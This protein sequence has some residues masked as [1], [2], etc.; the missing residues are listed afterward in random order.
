MNRQLLALLVVSALFNPGCKETT[1]EDQQAQRSAATTR[2]NADVIPEPGDQ[3]GTTT[4]VSSTK[5]G[6]VPGSTT[7]PATTTGTT[8]ALDKDP[9]DLQL[10]IPTGPIATVPPV[11]FE[12]KLRIMPLGASFTQGTGSKKAG[13]RGFLNK[14]L[15]AEKIDHLFVGS[16][17][18]QPGDLPLDQIQHEGHPGSVIEAGTSGRAGVVDNLSKWIGKGGASPQIIT[19]LVGSNDVDLNY[20][21]DQIEARYDK[22]LTMI[23]DAKTGL[24]PDAIV[25]ASSI[26]VIKDPVKE[27]RNK[28]YNKIIESLVAKH[29]A[30]GER[31]YFVD[32]HAVLTAGD[33]VDNLH[34]N[35]SGYEKV[36]KLFGAKI[37]EAVRIEN[38][39]VS[40]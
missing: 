22:L 37:K 9:N 6:S 10:P 16:N 2:N 29:K 7:A 17:K 8:S 33:M 31:I 11:R 40:K 23:L 25:I 13:Y 24:R 28:R 12:G 34:A 5:D 20:K 21:F 18:D 27:E 15:V 35:D 14:L 26:A 4:P 19:I 39:K 1:S 36:A 38:A 30:K 32:T 3:A